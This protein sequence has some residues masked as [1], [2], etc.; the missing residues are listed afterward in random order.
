MRFDGVAEALFFSTPMSTPRRGGMPPNQRVETLTASQVAKLASENPNAEIMQHV[1][2]NEFE[3]WCADRV[4][5]AVDTLVDLTRRSGSD[6]QRIAD[7]VAA[8]A[9][10]SELSRK[11]VVMC[12]KLSDI[13]FV[14]DDEHVRTLKRLILLHHMKERGQ[15]SAAAAH[16][17]AS[18][19]ALS[20]LAARVKK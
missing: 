15:I 13:A 5:R 7:G 11:Y 14:S 3:P 2:D 6:A 20:S 9:E 1:Y 16:A 10:L 12:R 18:D 17:Q 19:I 4:M 8:S